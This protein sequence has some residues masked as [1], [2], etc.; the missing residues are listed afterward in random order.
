MSKRSASDQSLSMRG[1]SLSGFTTSW[2]RV[3]IASLV[4]V[5]GIAWIAVYLL[6]A[7]KHAMGDLN[8]KGT[9]LAHTSFPWM[10]DMKNWNYLIGFGLIMLG[11]IIASH[12]TTPLGRGRGVVVGMLFCFLFGLAWV[13]TYYMASTSINSIPIM[14][15]LNQ[16]NLLVGVGFMAVGFSFA[17]KWE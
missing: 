8:S 16:Y 2:V 1:M 13:V 3:A 9:G 6:A 14:K 7:E 12:R 4:A 5:V 15:D 11:L 17:T 10:S